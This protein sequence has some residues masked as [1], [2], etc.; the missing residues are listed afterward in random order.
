M[1]QYHS[2]QINKGVRNQ[3]ADIW[4][5]IA[6]MVIMVHHSSHLNGWDSGK[7]FTTGKIYVEFFFILTVFL[8]QNM[9][10]NPE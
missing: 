9:Q 10:T 3:Y 1:K 7:P 4:R 8:R 2:E 5:L 6:A